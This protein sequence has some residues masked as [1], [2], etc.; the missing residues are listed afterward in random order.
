MVEK[1]PR[2]QEA[3]TDTTINIDT[4]GLDIQLTGKKTPATDG[5]AP[6]INH[7]TMHRKSVLMPW[8]S[9]KVEFSPKAFTAIPIFVLI[10]TKCRDIKIIIKVKVDII[11]PMHCTGFKAKR[12]IA[13]DFPSS[14]EELYCGE[15]IKIT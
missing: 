14:F 12:K 6:A 10:K 8:H 3:K 2:T 11:I 4:L 5:K 9:A 13:E 1:P 7:T 15:S